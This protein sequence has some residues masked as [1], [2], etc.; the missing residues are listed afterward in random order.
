MANNKEI[1]RIIEKY[2]DRFWGD[3]PVIEPAVSRLMSE[4]AY[5]YMIH[6]LE[7][8]LV[9]GTIEEIMDEMNR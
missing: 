3:V 2:D 6:M 5:E 8:P 4:R 7:H 9:E 1:R